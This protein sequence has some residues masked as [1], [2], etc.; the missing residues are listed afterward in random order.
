MLNAF[1]AIISSHLNAMREMQTLLQ[2]LQILKSA[3]LSIGLAIYLQR[4]P[5]VAYTPCPFFFLGHGIYARAQECGDLRLTL[6]WSKVSVDQLA[7]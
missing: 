2:S 7:N 5:T 1:N 3:S 6:N 4:R